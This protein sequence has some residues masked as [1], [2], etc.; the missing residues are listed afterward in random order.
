MEREWTK[1]GPNHTID[2]K[3]VSNDITSFNQVIVYATIMLYNWFAADFI[4]C[5]FLF[6]HSLHIFIFLFSY[7]FFCVISIFLLS[8]FW[9]T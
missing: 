8:L 2:T 6:S 4:V 9:L 1:V 5:C 7:L 3:D